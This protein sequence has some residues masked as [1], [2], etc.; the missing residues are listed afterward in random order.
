MTITQPQTECLQVERIN[1]F[2]ANRLG[3]PDRY[4]FVAHLGV[5]EQCASLLGDLRED[6]RLARI[7]LT[8]EERSTLGAIVRKAREEVTGRLEDDRRRRVPAPAPPPPQFAPPALAQLSTCSGRV[9]WLAIAAAWVLVALL[10]W[11][12]RR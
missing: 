12:F 11:F 6:E 1:S 4:A 2:L 5:C 7:P 9:S 8:P 10:W 3:A